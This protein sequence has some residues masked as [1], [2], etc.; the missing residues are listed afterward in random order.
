MEARAVEACRVISSILAMLFH[1][2]VF[3]AALVFAAILALIGSQ[4]A[5]VGWAVLAILA[6]SVR[7]AFTFGRNLPALANIPVVLS[8]SSAFLLLFVNAPMERGV[9]VLF[10]SIS[11]YI[12]ILGLYRLSR[13]PQD[14]SARAMIAMTAM[15][16]TFFYFS[17]AY[18]LYLNFNI[19]LWL[20]MLV[21]G[22]GTFAVM[23]QAMLLSGASVKIASVYSLVAALSLSEIAWVVN[24]WPFGYLT[25]GVVTLM[26]FYV[27]FDLAQSNVFG[28]LS[29][30][31]SLAHAGMFCALLVMVL[32]SSRWLPVG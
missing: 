13:A 32:Y 22:A 21:Y 14:M 18:G 11:Y 6:L 9:F 25:S 29:K 2:S 20:F 24:F 23:Y 17:V 16:T 5:F 8:V 7:H 10:S 26:F 28:T 4:P 12:L 1:L 15:V 31:R 27:L 19:P 30:R 3:F